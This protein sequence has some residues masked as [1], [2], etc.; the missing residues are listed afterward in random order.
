[1]ARP[2]SP[3]S[4]LR[5]GLPVAPA[6]PGRARLSGHY[7]ARRGSHRQPVPSCRQGR[8]G[9]AIRSG[10]HAAARSRRVEPRTISFHVSR[11]SQAVRCGLCRA[12]P[13]GHS[14]GH[15]ARSHGRGC[16]PA[17]ASGRAASPS[18]GAHPRGPDVRP[19]RHAGSPRSP[20][21]RSPSRHL[22]T[23]SPAPPHDAR[24][25][26]VAAHRYA[27]RLLAFARVGFPWLSR[28]G[29][30]AASQGSTPAPAWRAQAPAPK[31]RRAALVV[32]RPHP[33]PP[34]H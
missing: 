18:L 26:P 11:F 16:R 13:C 5:P 17:P 10:L 24:A 12:A 21:A 15:R 22:G 1:V 27:A 9:R 33:P 32:C 4:Q 8:A 19:N 25:K 28:S 2:S 14:V 23:R 31:D 20:G 34:H 29:E 6:L 7:T 30:A 3:S